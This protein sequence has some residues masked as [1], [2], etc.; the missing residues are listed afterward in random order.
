MNDAMDPEET[1]ADVEREYRRKQRRTRWL[2]ALI[3]TAFL[4]LTGLIPWLFGYGFLGMALFSENDVKLHVMNSTH[5]PAVATVTR[6]SGLF[7][8]SEQF[9]VGPRQIKSF[10]LLGGDVEITME[11]HGETLIDRQSFDLTNDLFVTA[12]PSLCF[13]VFDL[14]PLYTGEALPGELPIVARFGPDELTYPI[15][16]DAVVLPRKVHPDRKVGTLHWIEDFSCDTVD[17]ENETILQEVALNTLTM[18]QQRL[19][20]ARERRQRAIER[21]Q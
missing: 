17:P 7:P 19:Q 10:G 12:D 15:T 3:F 13:A 8:A 20:E 4:G 1:L 21:S 18:R 9:D 14:E 16:S 11:H 6:A 2:T 5:R